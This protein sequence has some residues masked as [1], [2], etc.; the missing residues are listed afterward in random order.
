MLDGIDLFGV[1]QLTFQKFFRLFFIFC[2]F[3][4]RDYQYI[5]ASR[6]Q[7]DVARKG[8][9][10]FLGDGTFQFVPA[11]FKQMYSLHTMVDGSVFPVAFALMEEKTAQAYEMVF[12]VMKD[13][14]FKLRH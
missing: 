2:A 11:K 1:L 8:R 4:D 13:E 12:G 6:F 10:I 14:G 3:L 9:G 5:F 7:L